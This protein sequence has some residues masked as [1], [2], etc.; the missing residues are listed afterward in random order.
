ML[1][2]LSA[3]K[4]LINPV[5]RSISDKDPLPVGVAPVDFRYPL[6]LAFDVL[7]MSRAAAPKDSPFSSDASRLSERE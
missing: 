2:D 1:K 3:G 7:M 6:E 5:G 4:R